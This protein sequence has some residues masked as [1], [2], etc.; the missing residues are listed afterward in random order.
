MFSLSTT[1][2]YTTSSP[3]MGDAMSIADREIFRKDRCARERVHQWLTDLIFVRVPL[4][5]IPR[6]PLPFITYHHLQDLC[7]KNVAIYTTAPIPFCPL[8]DIKDFIYK[9]WSR[10][11]IHST[12]IEFLTFFG[13]LIDIRDPN[14]GTSQTSFDDILEIHKALI[15]RHA[16]TEPLFKD[17]EETMES[18]NEGGLGFTSKQWQFHKIRALFRSLIIVVDPS[19]SN[20]PGSQAVHLVRTGVDFLG[21]PID[22]EGLGKEEDGSV[23]ISLERAVDF[24]MELEGR[25]AEALPEDR[26]M[27]ALDSRLGG[28]KD[29]RRSGYVGEIRGPTSSWIQD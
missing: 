29:I 9:K 12:E 2:S 15:D 6:Q 21:A 23:M 26:D 25:E 17:V 7:N 18:E 14:E 11:N 24:V 27:T 19:V 28:V 13:K 5:V 3:K 1:R 16:E 8:Q 4:K 10:G 22:F 20:I